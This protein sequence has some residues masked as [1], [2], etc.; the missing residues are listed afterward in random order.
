[1]DK[2]K[3]INK[4]KEQIKYRAKC[5]KYDMKAKAHNAI[6]WIDGNKEFLVIAIPVLAGAVAET[7]KVV[8]QIN[9]TTEKRRDQEHRERD[10]WDPSAGIHITCKRK[11]TN[12]E[13][14]EFSMRHSNGEA[15]VDILKDMRLI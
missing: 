7:R 9:N 1:M 3:K 14:I 10:I 4:I 11:L 2:T 8:N 6:V 5:I 13:R 15:T 12:A